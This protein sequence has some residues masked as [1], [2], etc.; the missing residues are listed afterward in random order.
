MIQYCLNIGVHVVR[1]Y[2]KWF[3]LKCFE[4]LHLGDDVE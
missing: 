4:W 1:V 2:L 3:I